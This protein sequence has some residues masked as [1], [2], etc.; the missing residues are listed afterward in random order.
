MESQSPQNESE[1]MGNKID[2]LEIL[3]EE[4]LILIVY[5]FL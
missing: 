5:E 4:Y 1:F 3:F 2:F